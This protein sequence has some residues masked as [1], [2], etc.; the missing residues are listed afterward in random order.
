MYVADCGPQVNSSF[1]C[2]RQGT[3]SLEILFYDSGVAPDRVIALRREDS[4]VRWVN[5]VPELRPRA[6]EEGEEA[7]ALDWG[8]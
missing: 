5:D 3:S 4:G 2:Q 7:E 1:S 6:V 8:C